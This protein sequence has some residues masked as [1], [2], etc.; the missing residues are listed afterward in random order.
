MDHAINI[1]VNY[2]GYSEDFSLTMEFIRQLPDK[3]KIA[4]VNR[5]V[6]VSKRLEFIRNQ[7]S[8]IPLPADLR[9]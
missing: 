3:G 4:L 5:I 9:D 6:K 8:A 2:L 1:N 7:G